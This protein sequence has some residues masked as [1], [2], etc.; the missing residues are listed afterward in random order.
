MTLRTRSTDTGASSWRDTGLGWGDLATDHQRWGTGESV[1]LVAT[2]AL[3]WGLIWVARG[4]P[5][6]PQL[7]TYWRAQ[8]PNDSDG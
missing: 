1:V 8:G 2:A 7:V 6:M 3:Y 5:P 4:F